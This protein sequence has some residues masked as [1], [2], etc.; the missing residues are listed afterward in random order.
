MFEFRGAREVE[1][2]FAERGSANETRGRDAYEAAMAANEAGQGAAARNAAA[3]A[4]AQQIMN[5]HERDLAELAAAR[6]AAG[7][8]QFRQAGFDAY[9]AQLMDAANIARAQAA[10]ARPLSPMP[11][12]ILAGAFG[13]FMNQR[14]ADQLESAATR[15][16]FFADPRLTAPVYGPTGRVTGVRDQYGRLTGRDPIADAAEQERLRLEGGGSEIVGTVQDPMTGEQKC[17]DGYIFD[18]DLQ[19][20]R[21]DTTAPVMQPLEPRMPTRTYGLL[22]QAPTGLLEFQRR[23]GLPQ[24][25][26][27]FSLLT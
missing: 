5:V 17:P 18:E 13:G 2:E 25:Q 23:Y 11:A 3:A 27:D 26:M 24:Q 1:R 8:E 6:S 21:L 22:D 16:R 19:A 9:Q 20:C 15:E 12:G 4:A 14:I 7:S 10:A